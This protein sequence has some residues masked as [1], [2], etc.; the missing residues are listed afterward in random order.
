VVT[1]YFIPFIGFV[2]LFGALW[3]GLGA[4]LTDVRAHSRFATAGA[5]KK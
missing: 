3:L 5:K 1:S 2:F 4:L